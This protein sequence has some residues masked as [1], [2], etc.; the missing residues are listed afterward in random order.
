[1]TV[2]GLLDGDG[3]PQKIAELTTKAPALANL[4]RLFCLCGGADLLEGKIVGGNL[5]DRALAQSALPLGLPVGYTVAEKTAFD[6][7]MKFSAVRLVGRERLSLIKGAPEVLLPFIQK[8]MLPD[9]RTEAVQRATLEAWLSAPAAEG[10]RVL[11]LTLGEGDISAPNRFGS[12]TFVGAVLLADR[13]RPQAPAAVEAP[14]TTLPAAEAAM[15]LTVAVEAAARQ[16][17]PAKA[18]TL[19]AAPEVTVVRMAVEAAAV[20][21]IV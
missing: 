10:W 5:T 20:S 17:L 15:D 21:D 19:T 2:G 11:A 8:R 6:S 7:A 16:A 18:L 4:Y 1:M 13:L 12:L 3:H 9:G 14:T